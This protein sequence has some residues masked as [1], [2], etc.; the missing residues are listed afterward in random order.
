MRLDVPLMCIGQQSHPFVAFR[1]QLRLVTVFLGI[2][3]PPQPQYLY[4][5]PRTLLILA[6]LCLANSIQAAE[7]EV[8]RQQMEATLQDIQELQK[9]QQK[10][11]LEQDRVQQQLRA[12]EVDIGQLEKRAEALMQELKKNEAALKKLH[13]KKGALDERR[14][15]QR[16]LIAVQARTAYQ[17][18][19]QEYLKLL[20]NQQS[21][22]S[23][24]R[25]LTYYQYLS[26]ARVDQL[27]A[28]TETLQQLTQLEQEIEARQQL[29]QQQQAELSS[30]RQSLER[31]RETRRTALA[32]LKREANT[33]ARQLAVLEQDR[34]QLE[35][36]LSQIRQILEANPVES[37]Q[38]AD[39]GFA[40]QRGM[41]HWPVAGRLI[42]HYGSLRNPTNRSHWDGVLI[43]AAAGTEVQAV[44]PGRVV[45]ADWLRGS[46]LLVI[47]DHGD[48]YLSLY[49]HNQ[50]LLRHAG[51][52]VSAG[53]PIATVG[54]SG[55]QDNAALYFAIRHQGRPSDPAQWCR[56]QG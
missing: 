12:T 40:G 33:K 37:A 9:L 54:N 28:F 44:H 3:Q 21:P 25:T 14:L 8:V 23:F 17:N 47:L 48:G 36:A 20:L 50:S 18:G 27:S 45:F 46:G 32:G 38:T 56:A 24:S 52:V 26:R 5:M 35:Q 30:Q 6:L 13:D 31:L 34:Q 41:L 10:L 2:L 22:E 16:H 39:K 4:P 29:I 1:I 7:P 49:G 15:E 55:G 53:D 43:Q 11:R 42:A 19:Q 51:D